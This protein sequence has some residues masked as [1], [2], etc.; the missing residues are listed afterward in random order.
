MIVFLGNNSHIVLVAERKSSKINI[1]GRSTESPEYIAL[2]A[3]AFDKVDGVRVTSR[4]DVIAIRGLVDKRAMEIIESCFGCASLSK[5]GFHAL[6]DA[7]MA[8]CV[9][10]IKC[11]SSVHVDLSKNAVHNVHI[12]VGLEL[13]GPRNNVGKDK[14][15]VALVQGLGKCDGIGGSKARRFTVNK[16]VRFVV[17]QESAITLIVAAEVSQMLAAE[18]ELK[19]GFSTVL[20]LLAVRA[21]HLTQDVQIS[22][23]SG[24]ITN[25]IRKRSRVFYK[26]LV[27]DLA[28]PERA[29]NVLETLP[30][31]AFN[32]L[33]RCFDGVT[34]SAVTILVQVD[35]SSYRDGSCAE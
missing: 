5:P 3:V 23:Y 27:V 6:I 26:S 15:G 35:A 7:D 33:G 25:L 20:L 24:M 16:S 11:F 18:E 34:T 17:N 1:R 4:Q 13:A 9:P 19:A 12:F 32:V 30:I 14:Q 29:P 2:I 28:L 10:R 8:T 22:E 21:I 31:F